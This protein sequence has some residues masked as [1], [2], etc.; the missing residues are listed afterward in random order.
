MK[1]L[2]RCTTVMWILIFVFLALFITSANPS[3]QCDLANGW[4]QFNS[5]CY[6]LEDMKNWQEAEDYCVRDQG[7]LVSI[8][9]EEQLSFLNAH[10]PGAAWVGLNDIREEGHFE[11][12]DGSQF[13]SDYNL[14]LWAPGQPDNWQNNEDCAHLRA[15]TDPQAGLL[16]DDFCTAT[17]EFICKKGLT[18][19]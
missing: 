12:T 7:H 13:V 5:N 11:Y 17:R 6:K 8:Y 10:M 4:S 16:N 9:S 2:V 18:S 1:K 14:I 3:T 15:P 19:I